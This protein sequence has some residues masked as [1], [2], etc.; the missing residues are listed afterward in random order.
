[1]P[2]T[3]GLVA[4][5]LLAAG[6]AWGASACPS[7]DTVVSTLTCSSTATGQIVSTDASSLG[8][9]CSTGDCYECGTHY[10][11]I[12]QHV[13]EDVYSLTCESH[14]AVTM[15]ISG[16][17]CDLDMYILDDTCDPYG[18]CVAGSTAASTTTDS[19]SFTCTA[20]STY[21]VVIEG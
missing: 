19:V 8:G 3:G 17:D 7:A 14:G 10:T 16:L 12:T 21:Y 1:M 4:L 9:S 5:A 2:Q 15:N 11:G 20:G 6:P 18:G 13:P